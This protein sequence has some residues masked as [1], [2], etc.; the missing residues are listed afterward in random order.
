MEPRP[1]ISIITPVFNREE[2]LDECVDSVK[3]QDFSDWELILVDDGS[4]DGSHDICCRRAAE[5]P[6]IRLLSRANGGPSRTRNMALDNACGR[7]ILFLDSDDLLAPGA[8]STLVAA[9]ES[10]GADIVAARFVRN[11][12]AFDAAVVAGPLS[13]AGSIPVILDCGEAVRRMLYQRGLDSSCSWKLFDASL[14]KDL[15]F[16]PDILY[17]DLELIPRLALK[18]EKVA[19]IPDIVYY[20]RQT[21]GSIVHTFSM[22][23]LDVLD[24]TDSMRHTLPS[25]FERAVAERRFSAANN[26]LA[27]LAVNAPEA[28]KEAGRCWDI[29]RQTRRSVLTDNRSRLK[30][31]IAALLSY[32]G[33][34]SLLR[35]L[36]RLKPSGK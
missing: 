9:A 26:I 19:L 21:P 33:G 8:L 25:G 5:D 35:F 27:L 13:S 7:Y 28:R 29:I 14:W 2:Y 17:E 36:A 15:R 20:Y 11:R 24:V 34:P 4:V 31:R 12:R 6:R 3:A 23:R 18:A 10:S 16:K 1:L 30:S 22:R 32:L